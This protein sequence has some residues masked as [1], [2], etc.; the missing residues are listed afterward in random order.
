[1]NIRKP[2]AGRAFSKPMSMPHAGSNILANVIFSANAKWSTDAAKGY[3]V[4]GWHAVCVVL[5]LSQPRLQVYIAFCT[6]AASGRLNGRGE[7]SW[8]TGDMCWGTLTTAVP[9]CSMCLLY[10]TVWLYVR[11]LETCFAFSQHACTCS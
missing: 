3:G 9:S 1:M 7:A 5:S 6:F 8:S 10:V 4:H 11:C 2:K